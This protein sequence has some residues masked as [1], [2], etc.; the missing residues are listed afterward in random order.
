VSLH[1]L[2]PGAQR[3]AKSIRQSPS[4]KQDARRGASQLLE[5]IYARRPFGAVLRDLGLTPNQVWG[6]TKTDKEW[7]EALEAALTATRRHDL[8]DGTNAAYVQGCVCSECREH[9]LISAI[10]H[11]DHAL[12]RLPSGPKL[13]KRLT[14]QIDLMRHTLEHWDDQQQ[15]KGRWKTLAEKHGE[16]ATPCLAVGGEAG[17]DTDL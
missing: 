16:H 15:S 11:L 10:H 14:D 13:L 7:A 3:Q 4:A 1:P 8:K 5:A 6:L 2:P 9:L 12:K 17:A